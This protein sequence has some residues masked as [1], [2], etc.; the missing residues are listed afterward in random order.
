MTTM[1]TTLSTAF[2]SHARTMATGQGIST[3]LRTARERLAARRLERQ[4]FATLMASI[5]RPEAPPA[6]ANDSA[7]MDAEERR[8]QLE[9]ERRNT[10]D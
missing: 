6:A 4:A 7:P 5:W 9:W 1:T 2:G 3:S 8:W 10:E